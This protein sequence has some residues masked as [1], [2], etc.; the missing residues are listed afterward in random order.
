M[1]EI[2]NRFCEVQNNKIKSQLKQKGYGFLEDSKLKLD[3]FETYYLFTKKKITLNINEKKL[4]EYCLKKIKNFEDKYLVYK[5]FKDKGYIVKDGAFFGFDFRI[6][7]N[8]KK[9]THT[10]Y[11]VDVKRTNKDEIN[12]IIK[13]ERL[14]NSIKTK[15][16]LAIIDNENKINKIKLE[17]F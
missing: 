1:I 3:L 15:Y 6:Y 17:R 7:E 11:V 4:K 2:K 10:K 13:S 8:T 12:K 9:H 14:A 5:D 16:I